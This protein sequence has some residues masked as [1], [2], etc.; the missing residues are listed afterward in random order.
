MSIPI[1][2]KNRALQLEEAK[3]D[4]V[5]SWLQVMQ[6]QMNHLVE[7]D[8]LRRGNVRAFIAREL[9]EIGLF[10]VVSGLGPREEEFLE[11]ILHFY[12]KHDVEKYS[13][14]I[15]PYHT[16]PNFLT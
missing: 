2:T 6:E 4:Y 5:D 11:E 16:S 10:N 3:A 7:I 9:Q 8:I 14:E 12:Q 13:L 15:N 1:M